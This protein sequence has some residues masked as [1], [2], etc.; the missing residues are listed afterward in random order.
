MSGDRDKL[1]KIQAIRKSIVQNYE[2]FY[3]LYQPVIDAASDKIMGVETLIRYNN[4]KYGLI[5]P[6]EFIPI[7]ER[8]P[9]FTNLGRWIIET[10]IEETRPLLEADP[11]IT[12]GINLSY[13]QLE[14]PGFVDMIIDIL[15]STGLPPQN[16][17]LEITERCRL[18]NIA[19]L[20]NIIAK[21]R[22]KGVRFAL[23]D[24][25]TGYSS[26]GIL[27]DLN[28]DVVKVDR[29]FVIDVEKDERER[30]LVKHFAAIAS[31]FGARTCV[32]GI[33]TA[34]MRD[35]IKEYGV[36]TFQGYFYSKPVKVSEI[37]KSGLM[38]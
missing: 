7:I 37:L 20:R 23:D 38:K 31:T 18:L 12:V 26:I 3:L 9:L 27:K 24:Y 21:L 15:D 28:V 8:D 33:E 35:I 2:G 14:E 34:E 5:M 4:P 17:T 22:S 16:L 13:S 32:E 6:D 29:S 10:A 11:S 36:T 1:E 25:G 19:L 30:E